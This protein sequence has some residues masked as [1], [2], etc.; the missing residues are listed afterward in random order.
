MK[1]IRVLHLT[2]HINIGGITTYIYLLGRGL[3]KSQ[4]ELSVFSSGGVMQKQLEDVGIR[5]FSSPFRTKS[6]LSPK[7]YLAVPELL[8]IVREEKI[9]LLHAHTRV[10]QVMAWWIQRITGIPYVSTCHGFYKRRLGRMLLP[11]WGNKVVA[12]SPP[13]ADSL[14]ADFHVPSGNVATILNAIDLENLEHLVKQKNPSSIISEY[15]LQSTAPVLG[16]VARV[17]RDKGHEY[18]L[19]ACRELLSRY[20]DLKLL[21]V[22]EG[23]YL[24]ELKKISTQLRLNQNVIFIG[25]LGDVTKALAVIDIFILPAVWRE[26]FGLSIVEAMALKKPVI[27]TNIWALNSLVHNRVN[28]LLIQPKSIQELEKAITELIENKGLRVEIGK[29]AY[30]TVKDQFSI[31]RMVKEFDRLYQDVIGSNAKKANTVVR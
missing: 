31:D 11:A 24:S 15:K 16:I 4:Y 3:N 6:E 5:V 25:S 19:K 17:V 9:D 1:K 26:G 8:R 30:Q 10:T 7:L 13:V 12:I 27:A 2:T 28:G 21:V 18:L 14:I 22:G 29:N 20:P 23:P